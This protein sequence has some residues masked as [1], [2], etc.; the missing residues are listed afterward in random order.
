MIDQSY[1]EAMLR[2]PKGPAVVITSFWNTEEIME[3]LF[4]GKTIG[5]AYFGNAYHSWFESA[6]VIFGDPSLVIFGE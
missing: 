6:Y 2:K 1:L 4:N 5:D 3:D